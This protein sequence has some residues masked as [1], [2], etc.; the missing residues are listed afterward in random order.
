MPTARII[1]G[2]GREIN[3]R[4]A[5]STT[6]AWTVFVAIMRSVSS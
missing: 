3:G 5:R 1:D 2:G 4:R 6:A